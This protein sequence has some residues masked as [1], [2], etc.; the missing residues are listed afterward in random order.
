MYLRGTRKEVKKMTVNEIEKVLNKKGRLG[1]IKYKRAVAMKKN[2]PFGEITQITKVNAVQ[3]GVEYDNKSI[4]K[5]LRENGSLPTE[6]Q[7]L[8]GVEWIIYKYVLKNPKTNILMLRYYLTDNTKYSTVYL[9]ADGTEISKAE[10]QPYMR[11][12]NNGKFNSY[13]RNLKLENIIS[14]E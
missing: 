10:I 3:F 7:G 11:A 9:K 2:N 1:S 5:E 8:N 4:T 14:I 13:V 6:N 12:V